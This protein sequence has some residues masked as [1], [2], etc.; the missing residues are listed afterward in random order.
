MLLFFISLPYGVSFATCGANA[1]YFCI[2]S[3]IIFEF[4]VNVISNFRLAEEALMGHNSP[5]G[6]RF[7]FIF[8]QCLTIHFKIKIKV[9]L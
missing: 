8:F 2:N 9:I 5:S 6:E 3:K 7:I 4:S 1:S